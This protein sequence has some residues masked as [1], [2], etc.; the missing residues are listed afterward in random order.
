MIKQ[1][2]K[3]NTFPEQVRQITKSYIVKQ[4]KEI[5]KPRIKKESTPKTGTNKNNKKNT[6]NDE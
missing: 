3:K 6:S 2:I 1:I 4:N 5:D